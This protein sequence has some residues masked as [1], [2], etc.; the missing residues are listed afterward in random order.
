MSSASTS[1]TTTKPAPEAEKHDPQAQLVPVPL[2]FLLDRT[3]SS[4]SLD[5]DDSNTD[6]AHLGGKTPG[7]AK[8]GGDKLWEDNWDDDDVE[9]EFSV[10]LRNELTKKR[11]GGD[12]MES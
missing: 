6:L 2:V 11:G 10:Q 12:A 9:D 4:L 1:K 7:L 3:C 5:W 8:S